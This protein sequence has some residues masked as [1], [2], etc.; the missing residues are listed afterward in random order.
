MADTIKPPP[1][2]PPDYI[3]PEGSRRRTDDQVRAIQREAMRA[4]LEHAATMCVNVGELLQGN[5][6]P[7]P[8]ETAAIIRNLRIE[9]ETP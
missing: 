7:T 9:G 2:P 4:A 8:N 6:T 3:G 5:A 1:L